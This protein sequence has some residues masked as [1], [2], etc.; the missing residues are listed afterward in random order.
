MNGDSSGRTGESWCS[1]V[2]SYSLRTE[3]Y[4]SALI[5]KI[6]SL[7]AVDSEE[8]GEEAEEE[9]LAGAAEEKP[10]SGETEEVDGSAW[11][12]INEKTR[13]QRTSAFKGFMGQLLLFLC[14][15]RLHIAAAA[16]GAAM[17][18]CRAVIM[19]IVVF[20]VCAISAVF[21]IAVGL[22]ALCCCCI[23][24]FIGF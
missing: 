13:A 2:I 5:C 7:S 18:L 3:S 6:S 8:T 4:S 22:T 15:D 19:C 11:Q 21:T 10:G 23:L 17:C 14:G 16:T 9:L 24:Y 20:D 1:R 12:P